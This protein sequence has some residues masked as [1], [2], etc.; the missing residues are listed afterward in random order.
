MNPL[1]DPIYAGVA[2][3]TLKAQ[4]I[5]LGHGVLLR[6][7]YAHFMAPYLM[8]FSPAKPGAPHPAP[9]SA[10]SGG[11]LAID[12]YAELY[13]PDSFSPSK[14]F[15]RLNTV[16]WIAS[17][18][19]LRNYSRVHVPVI[20]PQAFSSI[21]GNWKDAKIL[22]IEVQPRVYGEN[23][24]TE[25]SDSDADWL[26][27]I[28]FN[29]AAIMNS[30]AE[31]NDAYQAVDSVSQTYKPSLALITL[32]GALEH[33]FSPAT[34]ELRFRVSANIAAYLAPM[35]AE[36]LK[37][38][39]KLLKL[40]DSRSQAAHGAVND[41]EDELAETS[42]IA[43]AVILKIIESG[44]VPTKDKLDAILFGASDI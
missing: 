12:I 44:A 25:L 38:Q 2:G 3:I 39:K 23:A 43:R 22:P 17:L 28:W 9:W 24:L 13:I 7:T 20:A 21:P 30:N 4:E 8:A 26:A 41:C 37:L 16:W 10:V 40:Y 31:F 19:R 5:N 36:R 35:G 34:Q 32:W 15:D 27:N 6:Q 42:S 18:L 29:G 33:L 14:F 1:T 11:G